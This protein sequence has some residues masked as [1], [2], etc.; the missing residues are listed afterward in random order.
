M[1]MKKMELELN[2]KKCET[3]ILEKQFQI[4]KLE[5]DIQRIRD[6]ISIM[7]ENKQGFEQKLSDLKE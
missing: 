5:E 1:S 6:H 4:L 2:I 7:E 3:G